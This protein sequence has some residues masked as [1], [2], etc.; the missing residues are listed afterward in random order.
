MFWLVN[1]CFCCVRFHFS[2]PSQEIG[3]RNV[4][5]MTYFVSS[6]TQS[7]NPIEFS[8]AVIKV[9]SSYEINYGHKCYVGK[10]ISS[11]CW[12]FFWGIVEL[13]AVL[14]P[15]LLM[16]ACCCYTAKYMVSCEEAKMLNPLLPDMEMIIDIDDSGPFDPF[17][18][19]CVFLGN[20]T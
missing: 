19:K 1:A 3:F 4:S 13:W 18:V 20:F 10:L 17:P 6:G 15:G 7:I 8:T 5:E 16:S 12:N 9:V 2:V 14:A 11:K